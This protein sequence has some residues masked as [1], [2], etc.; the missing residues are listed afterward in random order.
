M[1]NLLYY[2]FLLIVVVVFAYF[3]SLQDIEQFT[4][5]I[6]EMY[7][8]YVRNARIAGEDLYNKHT[9][10]ITNLFRKVGIM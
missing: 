9:N 4:P 7:R 5:K 8:P 3:N 10:N 1:K 6:R 2:L